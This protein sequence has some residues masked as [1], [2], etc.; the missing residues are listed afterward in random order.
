MSRQPGRE[1]LCHL[2]F[3]GK[4]A[5]GAGYD[6]AEHDAHQRDHDNILE[7]N[8]LN[9]PNKGPGA[10]H[11]RGEGKHR[12]VPEVGIGHKQKGQQNPKLR[13]RNGGTRGR[14]DKFIH[15]QLLHDQSR[16]AHPDAGTQNG[17]QPRQA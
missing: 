5:G 3:V 8:A 9:K 11:C 16:H 10:Q 15:A 1:R 13:G 4:I 6:V 17:K 14:R 2:V 12:P 7:R